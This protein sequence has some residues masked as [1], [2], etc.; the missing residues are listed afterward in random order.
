M[1]SALPFLVFALSLPNPLR[2][3]FWGLWNFAS[4]LFGDFLGPA[5]DALAEAK[6]DIAAIRASRLRSHG[7][8]MAMRAFGF[9]LV[10]VGLGK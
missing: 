9:K 10:L 4:V 6:R 3:L 8:T 1:F 5:S 2:S 7:W